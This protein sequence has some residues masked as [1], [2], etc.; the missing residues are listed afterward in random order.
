MANTLPPF[1]TSHHDPIE[2]LKSERRSHQVSEV[3]TLT[4]REQVNCWSQEVHTVGLT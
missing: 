4:P 2:N 1:R 3:A